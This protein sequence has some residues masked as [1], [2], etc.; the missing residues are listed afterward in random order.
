MAF[1][2][3]VLGHR[4]SETVATDDLMSALQATIAAVEA[5]QIVADAKVFVGE[6][7]PDQ[8]PADWH[9]VAAET[10][11][12]FTDALNSALTQALENLPLAFAQSDSTWLWPLLVGQVPEP[13]ASRGF[14]ASAEAAPSAAWLVPKLVSAKNRRI[15]LGFGLTLTRGG[16]YFERVTDEY[17]QSQ[18]DDTSDLLAAELP[19]AWLRVAAWR[20]VGGLSHAL[21]ELAAPLDLGIRLRSAGWRVVAAPRVRVAQPAQLEQPTGFAVRS[22]RLAAGLQLRALHAPIW[23]ALLLGLL[24]PLA[25]LLQTIGL[26]LFKRPERI[27]PLWWV[28]LSHFFAL[29]RLFLLRRGVATTGPARR[30]LQTLFA[31]SDD[32]NRANRAKYQQI[33]AWLPDRLEDSGLN[34]AGLNDSGLMNSRSAAPGF[35]ASGSLWWLV[36]V[37]LLS[38]RFW[39]TDAAVSGG[40]L[41]P[42]AGNWVEVFNRAGSSWQLLNGG[43]A[44]PSDPFNW[45]LLVLASVSAWAPS[46]GVALLLFLAKPLAF[47]GAWRVLSL[48]SHRLSVLVLGA[49]A[50]AF[51]PSFSQTQ[52]EGRF[53]ALVATVLLPWFVFTLAGLLQLG[54]ARN[55]AQTWTWLATSALLAAAISAGAPSLTPVVAA[56]IL[57]LGIYRWRRLGYLIWL[58]VPLVALWA[59]LVAFAVIG[60]EHPLGL[61][62]EPGVVQDSVAPTLWQWLLG[63]NAN[64]ALTLQVMPELGWAAAATALLALGAP[65]TRRALPALWLWFAVALA[66]AAAWFMGRVQFINN[67]PLGSAGD[68]V[69]GS[70]LALGSLAGLLLVVLAAI[71]V[72]ALRKGWRAGLA[73]LWIVATATLGWQFVATAPALSWGSATQQPAV[74]QLTSSTGLNLLVLTPSDTASQAPGF[75]VSL[76]STAGVH[77]EDL[78]VAQRMALPELLSGTSPTAQRG[79]ALTTLAAD[80]IAANGADLTDRLSQLQVGF[81]LIPDSASSAELGGALDTFA[82]LEA[83]GKTDFGRLWRVVAANTQ[84]QPAE[85]PAWSVTKGVQ[86]AVLMFFGLLALPTRRSGRG[87]SLATRDLGRNQSEEG[88]DLFEAPEV[89]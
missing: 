42:L 40:S 16:Q 87:N 38:L 64:L 5:Q 58:P 76:Q 47:L 8:L 48:V 31:D 15:I 17:D 46:L 3:V 69:T 49:A 29:P 66:L 59:P 65:L 74:V 51:W 24:Q 84:L 79:E 52:L 72:D 36:L 27:L 1:A 22:K 12:N 50:F 61:L 85:Y 11:K 39:P 81:V 44:A 7:R 41:I 26:L 60:V 88:A 30:A 77:L 82:E 4:P 2:A 73:S 18:H 20:S 43:F 34:D 67:S 10:D 54:E 33:E 35:V 53:G 89:S 56:V 21:N 37:G 86:F 9:F 75:K 57:L 19:G 45:V 83:V 32:I 70:G 13:D 80:L 25:A 71:T 14:L 23:R 55:S 6:K 62:L 28:S 78:S 63:G 68:F